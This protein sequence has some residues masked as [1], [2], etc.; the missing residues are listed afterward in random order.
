MAKTRGLEKANHVLVKDST[1]RTIQRVK[2][3]NQQWNPDRVTTDAVIRMGVN[4][5][6]NPT[7]RTVMAL[8]EVTA[9]ALDR[10]V[11]EYRTF[12]QF[13]ETTESLERD[14]A[15]MCADGAVN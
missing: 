3:F 5:L 12:M 9:D 7:W 11:M 14:Y 1:L 10:A 15:E 13:G 8:D 2:K 6:D 4:L